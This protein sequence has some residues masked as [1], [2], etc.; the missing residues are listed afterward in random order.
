MMLPVKDAL[1]ILNGKWKLQIIVSLSFGIKRFSEMRKEIPGITDKML[2]KELKELEI[3]RLIT[4]TV[5]DKFPPVVEYAIT[6]H[7]ESLHSVFGR[8]TEMGHDT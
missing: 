3:N 4:R 5:Y 8:I 2:S 7:G 1:E 6:P